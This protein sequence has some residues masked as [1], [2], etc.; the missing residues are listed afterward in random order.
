MTFKKSQQPKPIQAPAITK[1]L[2][3]E[4]NNEL[5]A[6]SQTPLSTRPKRSTNYVKPN[7]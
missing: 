4:I 6:L 3:E 5:K 1:L 2:T 7:Y